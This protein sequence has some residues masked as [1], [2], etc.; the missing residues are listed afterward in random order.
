MGRKCHLTVVLNVFGWREVTLHPV[1]KKNRRTVLERH[2]RV[3][4]LYNILTPPAEG[5]FRESR[6][7]CEVPGP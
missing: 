1:Y 5:I 7:V 6:N 2:R 3:N 4:V